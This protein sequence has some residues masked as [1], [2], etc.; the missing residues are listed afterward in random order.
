[1]NLYEVDNLP[2]NDFMYNDNAYLYRNTID[3][4]IVVAVQTPGFNY[5]YLL[6]EPI[7]RKL[8]I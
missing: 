3:S 2:L 1:M 7:S 6:I 8:K 4:N 5:Q